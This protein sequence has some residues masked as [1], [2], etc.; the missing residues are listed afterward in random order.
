MHR[1]RRAGLVLAR[2]SVSREWPGTL[3]L[4]VS[5][6]VG[7]GVMR[8]DLIWFLIFHRRLRLAAAETLR[9]EAEQRQAEAMVS[10]SRA[11]KATAVA[12][13]KAGRAEAEKSRHQAAA[14]RAEAGTARA[15]AAAAAAERRAKSSDAELRRL[16][17]L[18]SVRARGPVC[19]VCVAVLDRAVFLTV[20]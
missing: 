7:C 9:R 20:S 14:A 16:R 8:F 1:R 10:R 15:E 5:T 3:R 17:D 13:S 19:P 12:I 4:S 6:A 2:S 11:E 18:L